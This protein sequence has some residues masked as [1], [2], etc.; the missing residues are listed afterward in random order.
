MDASQ[1]GCQ[2]SSSWGK[3]FG[4][5]SATGGATAF[6]KAAVSAVHHNDKGRR[7]ELAGLMVHNK[8]TADRYYLLEE[9]AAAAVKTSKY[10]TEV[11][12]A[13]APST[14]GAT[15]GKEVEDANTPSSSQQCLWENDGNGSLKKRRN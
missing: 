15:P 8:A 13:K 5:E 4:K 10:L 1:I 2:M 6:R 11:L 7:E 9:K 12:H 3:V 14:E